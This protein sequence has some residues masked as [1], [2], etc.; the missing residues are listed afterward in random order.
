MRA[1]AL[2]AA[3]LLLGATAHAQPV[4]PSQATGQAQI[5]TAP[6][7]SPSPAANRDIEAA[8]QLTM[9]QTAK[10]ADADLR[11]M[12]E[13]MQQTQRQKQKQRGMVRPR[14]GENASA[15]PCQTASV[16]RWKQCIANVERRVAT[17]PATDRASVQAQIDA[18][19]NDLEALSEMGE[20][21]SLRLQ[22]AMDRMSKL[23]E[24]LS[25][26]MK[27]MSDTQSSI[28]QNIK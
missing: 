26:L 14:T 20:M 11:A 27:K 4:R 25:N 22:M 7:V 16:T 1:I 17:L 12:M 5:Q 24:T 6:R 13:T 3:A 15:N 8:V 23:M 19:Q 2:A 21:D 10:D 9:M 28:I 18:L